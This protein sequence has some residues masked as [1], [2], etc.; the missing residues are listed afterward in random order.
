MKK[1]VMNDTILKFGY[2]NTK[3]KEYEY[4]VVLLRLDQVTLGSL[5]IAY[6]DNIESLSDVCLEGFSELKMVTKNVE[7]NLG[8]LFR[9]EKI[10]Y[11]A[12]MMVDKNVHFHVIPRYSSIRKFNDVSFVDFGWPKPPSLSNLNIINMDIET[13]LINVLVD[14]FNNNTVNSQF[15]NEL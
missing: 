10:N 8:N 7:T 15:L 6:K 11:L 14:S 13:K 2:P 5:I 12:L 9:F 1:Q 3:I 4:W